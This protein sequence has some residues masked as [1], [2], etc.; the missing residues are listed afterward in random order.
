MPE[1][2]DPRPARIDWAGA[3]LSGAGLIALVWGVIE[4]PSKGWTSGPVLAA[5]AG[6]ALALGAFVVQQRRATD[7]LLD[8]EL[9]RD[10]RFS[11]ALERHAT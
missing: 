4:A 8:L 11:A 6:A 7:P 2:R 9:F 10:P 5:F 3:G 1:S